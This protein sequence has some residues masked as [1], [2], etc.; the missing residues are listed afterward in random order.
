MK[1]YAAILVELLAGFILFGE[2]LAT[3]GAIF[4]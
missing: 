4:H 2:T 1:A 3:I